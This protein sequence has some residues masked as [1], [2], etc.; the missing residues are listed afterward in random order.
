[1][2]SFFFSCLAVLLHLTTAYAQVPVG[3][4]YDSD[5]YPFYGTYNVFDYSPNNVLEVPM[6]LDD[7]ISS[8]TIDS[9]GNR[10]EIKV[11]FENSTFYTPVRD[12]YGRKELSPVKYQSISFGKDSVFSINQYIKKDRIKNKSL[13]LWYMDRIDQIEFASYVKSYSNTTQQ[14]EI[15]YF[16]KH[17]DSTH[18]EN[19]KSSSPTRINQL[20]LKYFGHLPELRT[21]I[22]NN[23]YQEQ[24]IPELIEKLRYFNALHSQEFILLDTYGK[25]VRNG[26]NDV[27]QIQVKKYD[28]KRWHVNIN[29]NHKRIESGYFSKL[30]PFIKDS[31]FIH[32]DENDTVVRKEFYHSNKL[33]SVWIYDESGVLQYAYHMETDTFVSRFHIPSIH[34]VFTKANYKPIDNKI[35]VDTVELKHISGKK[36]FHQRYENKKLVSSYYLENN[37]RIYQVLSPKLNSKLNSIQKDLSNFSDTINFA[38]SVKEGAEGYTLLLARVNREG[39]IENITTLFTPFEKHHKYIHYFFDKKYKKR[40]SLRKYKVDDLAVTYE[41]VIPV[42]FNTVAQSSITDGPNYNYWNNPSYSFPFYNPHFNNYY[43]PYNTYQSIPEHPV[44]PKKKQH[45]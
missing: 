1:M 13:F 2:K 29:K 20:L 15:L 5:G 6:I 11:L 39:E 18:W 8:N 35:V 3:H 14:N 30:M 23:N 45:R 4:V 7:Y 44:A 9:A 43:H 28:G 17:I 41:V 27:Y 21:D 34:K 12:G 37:K 16:A 42:R 19:I 38:S 40:P 22:E 31:I 33:D 25:K 32:Y 26:I 24:D 10:K 36:E